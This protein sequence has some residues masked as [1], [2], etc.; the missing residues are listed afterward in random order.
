[1]T[2]RPLL[3]IENLVVTFTTRRGEVRA[4]RGVS[5]DIRPGEAVGIVGESGSGKSVA[6]QAALGLVDSP[7]RVT[8]NV[9][10][11]GR[12]MLPKPPA[13]V[14]GREVSIVF[15]DSMTS[16]DPLATVGA[17]IGEVLTRHAGLDRRHARVRAAELLALVGI[18]DGAARLDLLPHQL[19]GGLRQR[20]MIA[21]ALAASPDLL[22]ADEPTTALD[23]TVQAQVVDL[24]ADLREKLGLA[25]ALITHDLGLV[26]E[27]CDSVAV[28]YAGRIVE[29]AT[30]E[31]FFAAPLHPYADGLLHSTPTVEGQRGRMEGIPGAPPDPVHLPEGCA[32]RPRCPR[33]DARCLDDPLLMNV[34]PGR[35]VACWHPLTDASAARAAE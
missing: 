7:G 6:M 29:T 4:V 12:P 31:A 16:L 28:M 5:L 27:F 23:V 25:V 11:K 22:I 17:Q 8:G 2:D 19:S 15:Q 10:W 32:F 24:L 18:V 26:A 20:V 34:T 9:R 21:I 30:V 14:L 35:R 3:E 1:M 33:A 13:G